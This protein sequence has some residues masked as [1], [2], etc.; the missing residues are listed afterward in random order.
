M[1][2][3]A[4]QFFVVNTQ[5]SQRRNFGLNYLLNNLSKRCILRW[6]RYTMLKLFVVSQCSFLIRLSA[7]HK[8]GSLLHRFSKILVSHAVN[9]ELQ[10]YNHFYQ[11]MR[12][13]YKL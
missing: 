2:H 11:E 6:K 9:F 12:S 4:A 5:H 7:P 10:N 1:R 8:Y 13:F 3:R